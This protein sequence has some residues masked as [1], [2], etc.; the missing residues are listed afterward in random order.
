MY[1]L[2]RVQ[3]RS[4]EHKHNLVIIPVLQWRLKEDTPRSQIRR[5]GKSTVGLIS[6][7]HYLET[8][9]N[10]QTTTKANKE[11]KSKFLLY[12]TQKGENRNLGFYRKQTF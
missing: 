9:N 10:D 1:V 8:Q 12:V 5:F 2:N 6:V 4:T 3:Y 7:A 11:H